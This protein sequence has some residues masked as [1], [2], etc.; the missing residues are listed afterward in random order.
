[1][2]KK[3]N[4]L[5]I[6]QAIFLLATVLVGTILLV[7]SFLTYRLVFNRTDKLIESTSKEINKQVVLNYENSLNN[8]IDTSN[9]LQKYIVD[10]T[11]KGDY[12]LLSDLFFNSVAIQRNIMNIALF[13]DDGKLLAASTSDAL[14]SSYTQFDWFKQASANPDIH[15]FSKPHRQDVSLNG[16][17]DVFSVSKSVE[18]IQDG[19]SKLGVLL[20][21]INTDEFIQLANQ[22]NLGE[23]GHII[24]LDSTNDLIYAS[25][26][27]CF[28][29]S[30]I[31]VQMVKD[32]VLG[33]QLQAM[34]DTSMYVNVNTITHTRWK[35][36]TF[37]NVNEI[38]LAK[39]QIFINISIIFITTLLILAII[40]F[41]F[42]RRINDPM[43]QLKQ[44]IKKIEEG[45]FDSH[46]YVTGQKEVVALADAFNSMSDRIK[47]LMDRV[48]IEQREKRK[49]HFKALQN[50]I[51]PHFLYNTLDSIVWLSENN[52]NKDVE[53][54]II[55][56]SKFFRMS[57]SSESNIVPLK[58]EIEHV[59][60]YLLIQQIRYQNS[61]E[62]TID[63]QDRILESDVL[64]LSLQPLVENA[65]IHGIKPDEAFNK[66]SIV[67]YIRNGFIYIEVF[68]EGYGINQQKIDEIMEMLHQEKEST[69][70]GL[71]NVYQRLKLYYGPNADLIIESELDEYTKVSMKI[72]LNQKEPS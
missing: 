42:A 20:I 14:R 24:I 22:T 67:G 4:D 15:Y 40:S 64:K 70:M 37:I 21:D 16:N 68:N 51:N 31:S 52:R 47:D 60:N 27:N 9:S 17:H 66:I 58:D 69:S 19:Q 18:Y 33:G 30:C 71:K 72:P 57:I 36:G 53:K 32:I 44:Y 39:N 34:N 59:T 1:M 61:F 10:Y 49:T 8:V 54:A 28:D 56:L 26:D 38:S 29:S 41:L 62:F 45:D 6:G 48:L 13:T 11:K 63:I 46:V 35:M 43:N 7:S 12:N 50:Q 55:A 2:I 23:N 5:S 3:L 65:I 25:N